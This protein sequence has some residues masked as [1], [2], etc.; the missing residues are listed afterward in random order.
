[1][2][3]LYFYPLVV[4]PLKT[5]FLCVSSQRE[6]GFVLRLSRI[7]I[8]LKSMIRTL[9][10][11]MFKTLFKTHFCHIA[12]LIVELTSTYMLL[13]Y[14]QPKHCVLSLSL[15]IVY[16][17][18]SSNQIERLFNMYSIVGLLICIYFLLKFLWRKVASSSFCFI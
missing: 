17:D 2:F 12:F 7:E 11:Y 14:T 8:K 16:I 6:A 15:F 18:I 5:R 1:M 9:K 10:F 3:L 13:I 4:R